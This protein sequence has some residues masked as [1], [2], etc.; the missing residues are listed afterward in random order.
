MF[1]FCRR[2]CDYKPFSVNRDPW[3]EIPPEM[4]KF[5]K[6]MIEK[7]PRERAEREKE[8]KAKGLLPENIVVNKH[9][10]QHNN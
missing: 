8:F 6:M 10:D 4:E 5:E 1:Y 7:M 9:D 2:V 3:L